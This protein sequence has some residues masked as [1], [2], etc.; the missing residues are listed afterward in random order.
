MSDST[1]AAFPGHPRTHLNN[2]PTVGT[3]SGREGKFFLVFGLPFLLAGLFACAAGLGLIGTDGGDAP[4]AVVFA[5]G[6]VFGI[7]GAGLMISGA[8]SVLRERALSGRLADYHEQPW[9]F[10][11]WHP[12]FARDQVAGVLQPFAVAGFLILFLVPFNY[13]VFFREGPLP[14]KGI[15]LLFDALALAGVGHAI[16]R[17]GRRVKY[18]DG[19][20]RYR[21]LPLFASQPLRVTLR[22]PRALEGRF[23]ELVVTLRC[24]EQCW[25]QSGDS[26]TLVTTEIYREERRFGAGEAHRELA[27]QY[28]LPPGAP[29]T[30]LHGDRVRFYELEVQAETPGIDYRALYLLPVYA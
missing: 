21:E 10:D 6:A 7:V 12:E 16:Y 13:F 29:G 20:L 3:S 25:E 14:V 11:G 19:Q 22:F 15:V 4:A 26:K 2:H 5:F 9:L 17:L 23:A 28:E 8:R 1:G 24:A 30:E 18:H 27:L